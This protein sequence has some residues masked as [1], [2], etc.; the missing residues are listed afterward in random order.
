[1]IENPAQKE[2]SEALFRRMVDNWAVQCAWAVKI[3]GGLSLT[4]GDLI[5]FSIKTGRNKNFLDFA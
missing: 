4:Q 2:Q 3:S 1:L 5:L